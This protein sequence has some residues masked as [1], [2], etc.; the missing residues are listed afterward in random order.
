MSQHEPSCPALLLGVMSM[1]EEVETKPCDV[2][3]I[4]KSAHDEKGNAC[5]S[6]CPLL[7]R[8]RCQHQKCDLRVVAA[9]FLPLM[10]EAR[11]IPIL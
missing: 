6:H 3:K 10:G 2:Q 8:L 7:K 1:L 9:L 11:Y 4:W 5:V